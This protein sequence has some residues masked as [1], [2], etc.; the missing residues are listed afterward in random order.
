L[1]QTGGLFEEAKQDEQI[2]PGFAGDPN[3]PLLPPYLA[4]FAN[5]INVGDSQ[6][7]LDEV[8]GGLNTLTDVPIL[9]GFVDV[10]GPVNPGGVLNEALN[11]ADSPLMGTW[12]VVNRVGRFGS[13]KAAQLREVDLTGPYFHNGGKL[14]LRQ[15][16]DFYSRGGDFP[17]TNAKHRDF[18]MV[19]MNVDVQ[20]NLS[21]AE[22]VS[23]V[24]FLLELTDDR[25]LNERAPFDHP[26]MIVPLDGTA[27]ENTTGRDA[28][29]VACSPLTDALLGGGP[30]RQSCSG[31]MFMDVPAVG[32]GGNPAGPLPRFL[33]LSAQRLSGVAANVGSAACPVFGATS[34]YCH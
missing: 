14:T 4:P 32:A 27:P 2:N 9:E 34:Q 1:D 28:M 20:S 29:L 17:V 30:G 16:V 3:N 6:P 10:L 24:D 21:E 12:P 26:Q 25:V 11:M 22:K 5:Q 8:F 23:L 15:V 13:F 33:G 19:N 18:N 31:G 7:E